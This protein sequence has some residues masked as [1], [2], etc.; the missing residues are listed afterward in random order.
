MGGKKDKNE[1][2]DF[3]KDMGIEGETEDDDVWEHDYSKREQNLK[4]GRRKHKQPYKE[5][6]ISKKEEKNTIKPRTKIITDFITK[7]PKTVVGD[8]SKK[9]SSGKPIQYDDFDKYDKELEGETIERTIHWYRMWFL[10]L[11]LG[12]EYE[13]KKIKVKNEYVKID[14]RFYRE[15]T[16]NSIPNRTFD[17]WWKDHRHLFVQ[18]QI[19]EIKK[20]SKGNKQDYFHIR[21]PKHRNQREVL[22]ELGIFIQGKTKGDKPKYPFSTTKGGVSYLKLHQQYNCLI[23]SRNGCSGRQVGKWIKDH[24]SHIKDEKSYNDDVGV[25]QVVSRVL[26]K[27]RDRLHRTSRGVFP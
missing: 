23:L 18:E 11:K 22:K 3:L 6:T 16:V 21:I 12:L 8:R 9:K 24:Y 14:R 26:S 10:F 5:T 1:L 17:N 7:E 27:G 25:S 15:W 20:I 19:K 4:G 13:K 2:K